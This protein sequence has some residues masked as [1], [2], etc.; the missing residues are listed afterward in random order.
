[1]QHQIPGTATVLCALVMLCACGD[2]DTTVGAGSSG[3]DAGGDGGKTGSVGTGGKPSHTGSGGVAA[4]GMSNGRHSISGSITAS[5][6]G[7]VAVELSGAAQATVVPDMRGIYTFPNLADGD[8]VVTPSLFGYTFTPPSRAV[9]LHGANVIGQDFAAVIGNPACMTGFEKGPIA[10]SE[11]A[12]TDVTSADLNGD[13]KLDLIA[14]DGSVAVFLGHGDGT[15]ADPVNYASGDNS[16][17]ITAADLDGDKKVDLIATAQHANT[18]PSGPSQVI[19]IAVLLGHGDGTF[20]D[21]VEYIASGGGGDG[22]RATIGDFDGDEKLDAAVAVTGNKA[23]AV[24]LGNGDGTFGDAVEFPS[25]TTSRAITSGDF[26]GD[27]Q[28][29]LVNTSATPIENAASV[30]LGN[31][32]GSFDAAVSYGVGKF[33]YSIVAA[34]WNADGKLDLATANNDGT[35]LSVLIGKGDGTFAM[36]VEYRAEGMPFTIASGDFDGDGKL[37]LVS[38]NG[39]VVGAGVFLG[40][41]DGTFGPM[42]ATIS[43]ATGVTAGDFDADGKLDIGVA[44]GG[45]AAILHNCR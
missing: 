45:G 38:G 5:I 24:L 21:A 43:P 14:I 26:N 4:T 44:G 34:D 19:T 37:D 10:G 35:N 30:L 13:D 39:A 33:P 15:L 2:D 40:A 22:T 12:F 42:T 1:M 3:Q 25:G 31:G 29:D 16:R 27:K 7:G 28:L 23:V 20:E 18:E 8:Y 9:K 41:G 6:A 36:S 32:D 17:Y 11:R